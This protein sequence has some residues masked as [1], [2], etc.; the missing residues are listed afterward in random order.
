MTHGGADA[1]LGG[2]G[3]DLVSS[4]SGDDV[5]AGGAGDDLLMGGADADHVFGDAGA[6]RVYGGAGNDLLSGGAGADTVFGGA[7]DDLVSA[8]AGDGN[9]VYWGEAGVDTYDASASSSN[10]KIDVG[11]GFGGKGS[12]VG[13]DIGSDTIWGFENIV[14][15]S[16]NDTI[17]AS[18][19][20]NV[21]D[22][23]A[24]ADVFRFTSAAAANGDTILG[25]EPGDK[26][27]LSAID[28]NTGTV[29]ADAFTIVAGNSFSAAGQLLVSFESTAEG[30]FT[31]VRGNVDGNTDADFTLRIAGHHDL[32]N[33]NVNL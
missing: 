2:E 28:A 21:I 19:A 14:A 33:G 8:E 16:G 5:V 11:T 20:V 10:L 3:A 18:N 4:G 23:G 30:D 32:N 26:L 24:G 27:D 29:S 1:V 9:D 6:D 13:V 12:V 7:G 31:V 25:F 17:T 22:G 15:G